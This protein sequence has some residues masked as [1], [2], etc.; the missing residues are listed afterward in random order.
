MNTELLS[1]DREFLFNFIQ[2]PIIPHNPFYKA[3]AERCLEL[4]LEYM[5][6]RDTTQDFVGWFK[7]R[8]L[9]SVTAQYGLARTTIYHADGHNKI[10]E[11]MVEA[12]RE[13]YV[14]VKQITQSNLWDT[15]R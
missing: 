15:P 3:A 14:R 7:L 5:E 9:Y 4:F 10:L 6:D 11:H 13:L 12:Y 8:H 2:Q 1:I